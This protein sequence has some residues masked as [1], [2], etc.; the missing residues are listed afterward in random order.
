LC[1]PHNGVGGGGGGG[2]G[3]VG[4][5]GVGRGGGGGGGGGAAR[6]GGGG[7]GGGGSPVW[8]QKRDLYEAAS[9]HLVRV[10]ASAALRNL[11]LCLLVHIIYR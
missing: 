1:R 10:V 8:A 2:G 5:G 9:A 11:F 4:G 7:G 3:G 6:G